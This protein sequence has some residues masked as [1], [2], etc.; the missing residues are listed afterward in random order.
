VRK[1]IRFDIAESSQV[2]AAR[3]GVQEAAQAA[4][5][6]ETLSG[7]VAIAVNELG[8]NLIKH[9]RGGELLVR[10][11]S[12][13]EGCGMELLS[14]DRGPGIADMALS[15]RDGYST[16]GSM[17]AGLGSLSRLSRV[18]DMHSTPGKGTV[19]MARFVADDPRPSGFDV[20]AVCQA[21]AGEEQCGDDWTYTAQSDRYMI[22]LADGLGHGPDARRAAMTAIDVAHRRGAMA[23]GAVLDDIHLASR[24]T[25]G[26]AVALCAVEH[27]VGVCRFAGIGNVA[28]AVVHG[29]KQRHFASLNGIVG[30]SVRKIQEFSAPWPGGAMLVMHSDGLATQWNLDRY[31]GLALRHPAVVAGVLYRDFSRGSDDVTVVVARS[32]GARP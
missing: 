29:G 6:D 25:R 1:Q 9:G 17:G 10:P 14:I 28:C 31:P 3:R 21:K 13:G 5:F 32:A 26:A 8:T 27:D 16:G 18:F 12:N 15:M 4:G 20:G 19:V 2:G 24:P 30:H 23:P 22:V 7:K 11:L